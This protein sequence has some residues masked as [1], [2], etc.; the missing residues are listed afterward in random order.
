MI[1]SAISTMKDFAMGALDSITFGLSNVI[2]TLIGGAYVDIPKKWDDSSASFPQ[3]TFN[4]QLISPYGNAI[5]QLQNI[6]IPLAMLL[7]GTLPL[8]AGKSSYTSPFLCSM[9]TKGIQH[10][11]L[12][13]I[14]S[15]SI[16]R[17]TSN[18]PFTM[19][20]KALAIDVSFTVTDFSN[21]MTAPIN[22]SIFDI[23]SPIIDDDS[24]FATYIQTLASRSLLTSKYIVPKFKLEMS[25]RLMAVDKAL[26][27]S[28]WGMRLGDFIE[29]MLSGIAADHSL[30]LSQHSAVK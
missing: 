21:I 4:I 20:K 26:S 11:K 8:S 10:I 13:M 9:F 17:G 16:T 15:L 24:K 28:Q 14:T 22:A 7:A 23:F 19:D 18:L 5:S 29:P 12:G 27:S 30:S 6:Y 1:D 3:L 25:R 2:Q